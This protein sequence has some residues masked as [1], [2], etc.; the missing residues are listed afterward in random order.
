[1]LISARFLGK[2][3][4]QKEKHE[5]PSAPQ[6]EFLSFS[7]MGR[8]VSHARWCL[9]PCMEQPVVQEQLHILDDIELAAVFLQCPP[10]LLVGDQLGEAGGKP[11]SRW[12]N[13]LSA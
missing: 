5:H 13:S 9:C 4:Y 6:K 2:V 11:G 3:L 1:M 12:A 8:L 7:S 10:N